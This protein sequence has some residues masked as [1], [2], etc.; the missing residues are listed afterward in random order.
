ME[1]A[2]GAYSGVDAGWS[3]LGCE[4]ARDIDVW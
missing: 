4:V 1:T 2:S 3:G